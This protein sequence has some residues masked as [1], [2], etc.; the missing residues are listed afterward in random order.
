MTNKSM[1]ILIR[2]TVVYPIFFFNFN[3]ANF[4]NIFFRKI[5]KTEKYVYVWDSPFNL[6]NQYSNNLWNYIPKVT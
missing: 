2:V 6:Y 1:S 4:L 5:I 3:K